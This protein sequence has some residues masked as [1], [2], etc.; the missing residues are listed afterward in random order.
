MN[1]G[2]Y[3]SPPFLEVYMKTI[4][5]N[6]LHG[7][8]ASVQPDLKRAMIFCPDWQRL[9]VCLYFMS[10]LSDA[11]HHLTAIENWARTIWPQGPFSRD[12]HNYTDFQAAIRAVVNAETNKVRNGALREEHRL[13]KNTMHGFWRNADI[14][15]HVALRVLREQHLHVQQRGINNEPQTVIPIAYQRRLKNDA[16]KTERWRIK[17]LARIKGISEKEALHSLEQYLQPQR[18]AILDHEQVLERARDIYSESRD[19]SG[20]LATPLKTAFI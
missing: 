1:V 19:L 15:N 10:E 20:L 18:Q 3:P 2:S 8:P 17:A 11:D 14:G 6:Q 16:G 7:I 4:Y 13:W 12:S 9:V 5:I